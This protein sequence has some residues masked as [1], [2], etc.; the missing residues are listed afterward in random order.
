[1]TN[2]LIERLKFTASELSGLRIFEGGKQCAEA[3]AEIER[4]RE[5]LKNLILHTE[6]VERFV[7]GLYIDGKFGG[8]TLALTEAKAALK[9]DTQDAKLHTDGG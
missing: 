5:G 4:L 3:A 6:R 8:E 1:M 2:E 9:G 7:S